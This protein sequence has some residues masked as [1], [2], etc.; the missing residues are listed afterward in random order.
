MTYPKKNVA[1]IKSRA[2]FYAT[3]TAFSSRDNFII[4]FSLRDFFQPGTFT[5]K[6]TLEWRMNERL[7]ANVE[8]R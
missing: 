7:R 4:F 6:E 1:H 3:Y 2:K 8:V 5:I